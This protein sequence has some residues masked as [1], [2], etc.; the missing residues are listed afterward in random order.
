MTSEEYK[1]VLKQLKKY[2]F[3]KGKKIENLS[4]I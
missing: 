4:D 3:E 1:K 2:K